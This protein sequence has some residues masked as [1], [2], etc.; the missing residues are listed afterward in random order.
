[1]TSCAVLGVAFSGDD[2]VNIKTVEVLGLSVPR[3]LLA[4][5]DGVIE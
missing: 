2:P 5:A 1:M 3:S 4:R